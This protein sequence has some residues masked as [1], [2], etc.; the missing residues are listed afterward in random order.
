MKIKTKSHIK[1]I[2]LL[3][4]AL[5]MFNCQND[6]NLPDQ[7]QN[8]IE[9][10]S[11]D[12]AKNFLM[13][14]R[15]NSSA[16]STNNEFENLEFNKIAQEKIKGTDQL[17]TVIPFTTN[18]DLE[19]KRILMLKIDNDVKSV[20]FIM[21][22]DENSSKESFSGELFSYSL[23]GNF[24]SGFRAKNGIIVSQLFENTSTLKTNIDNGKIPTLTRKTPSSSDGVVIQNNYR[25]TV[26][27]LDM[28]GYSSIFGNDIFG[29]GFNDY[30]GVDYYSWDAGG[31]GITA[32]TVVEIINQ[33][34]GKAKCIYESLRSSSSGFENAIKKFD[35][36]FTVSHL[37]L[38]INN[39]LSTNVYGQTQLPVNFITEIQI[40]NTALNS[41]SDLGK[42]TVFAHEIIH[43]EIYRKMLS[44]AQIGTLTPDGSNMTAQQQVNYINSM[45]DNFPGLYDYYFKRYK[46]TWNHEMMANHYKGI[47]ADV[48]Q[49]FDNN[50]LPR[51]TYEAVSWVGLGKLDSNITTIAWDNLSLEEKNKINNL[52]N[53]NF[54]NGPS[55]CY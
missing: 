22:P 20:V 53:D 55:N 44:A 30:G 37:K 54:Y 43:A 33:L 49:Q 35:G 18:N 51:S 34:T 48:I 17:L 25:K 50:R 8:K 16:K 19:N 23:D 52:I 24:I 40:S 39:N 41:L 13:H 11:I 32:P 21:Y 15:S 45:K 42:A 26:Q 12:E 46:P 28:F 5:L 27:A 7:L 14:S 4:I 38:T 2:M 10:V 9:T 3:F 31:G 47:I 6:E 1:V 36:D 29:G